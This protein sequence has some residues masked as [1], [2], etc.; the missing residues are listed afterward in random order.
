VAWRCATE[1]PASAAVRLVAALS[2]TTGG[3][4]SGW[5][6]VNLREMGVCD[7]MFWVDLRE[8]EE[9]EDCAEDDQAQ[10]EPAGPVIPSAVSACSAVV[11]VVITAGHGV[12]RVF[13][14]VRRRRCESSGCV[15]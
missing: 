5:L 13:G 14:R 7:E 15:Q 2:A 1:S 9:D 3:D 4:T 6:L 8:E 10:D 11:S 12:S